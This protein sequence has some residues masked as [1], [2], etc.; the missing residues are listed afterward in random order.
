[1]F[2]CLFFNRNSRDSRVWTG[3]QTFEFEKKSLSSR[4][5]IITDEVCQSI[6]EESV[7]RRC[8]RVYYCFH[9]DSY[10]GLTTNSNKIQFGIFALWKTTKWHIYW[11]DSQNIDGLEN[12]LD[13]QVGPWN[14]RQLIRICQLVAKL[15]LISIFSQYMQ[16]WMSL[17]SKFKY[18]K[19]F[20]LW[21]LKAG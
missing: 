5:N 13:H 15:L 10:G 17:R 21:F 6:T 2:V 20:F 16:I 14:G 12:K 3:A 18:S 8:A 7:L 1:M 11:K 9:T 4:Q 19:V